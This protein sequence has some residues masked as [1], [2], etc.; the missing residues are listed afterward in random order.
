MMEAENK[1]VDIG[2]AQLTEQADHVRARMLRRVDT[3]DER[4][5]ALGRTMTI[6]A[7]R[8]RQ[9]L[10]IIAGVAAIA[11]LGIGVVA[12]LRGKRTREVFMISPW[13]TPVVRPQHKSGGLLGGMAA[14]LLLHFAKRAGEAAL[15]R[16]VRPQLPPPPR[17]R[18]RRPTS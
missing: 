17:P 11:V 6:L 12:L 10:P 13:P 9:N 5:H 15:L 7:A 16:A 2:R 3:L 18:E 8:A 14:S 1:N 4:R